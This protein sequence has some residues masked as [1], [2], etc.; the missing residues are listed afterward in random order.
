M[1]TIIGFN[2]TVKNIIS[3]VQKLDD[4]EQQSILAYLRAK[5]MQKKPQKNLTAIP[6][7]LSMKTID[8]IKHKSRQDARK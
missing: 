3:E 7:R 2:T 1:A 4:I 5:K 6:S 8:A